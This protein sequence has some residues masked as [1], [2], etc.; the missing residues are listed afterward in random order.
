MLVNIDINHGFVFEEWSEGEKYID[1]LEEYT[2]NE[3]MKAKEVLKKRLYNTSPVPSMEEVK[4]IEKCLVALN[5]VLDNKVN[6][7]A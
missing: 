6:L 3:A 2:T 4:R 7:S 1:R 5:E